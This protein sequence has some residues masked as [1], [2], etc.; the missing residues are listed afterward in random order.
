MIQIA[1]GI[2][3][4]GLVL[5][6]GYRSF[7]Q[8]AR[9]GST[10]WAGIRRDASV[11]ERI[12]AGLFV[13]ALLA[14]IAGLVLAASSVGPVA[15]PPKTVAVVGLAVEAA[16]LVVLIVAQDGMGDAW[17]IGVDPDEHTD[18]VTSGL[19]G[20][21]RNPIFTA[22]VAAQAG[23]VIVAPNV[24]GVAAL[25]ALV[26][27]VQLQVRIVE[28]PYLQ[29]T[30]PMYAAYASRVGRFVPGIGRLPSTQPTGR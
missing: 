20:L 1:L 27:A 7:A 15:E 14:G 9:T 2:Y 23:A 22:M 19:F 10:G 12:A 28:E 3:G 6:F 18:L 16:G 29:R 21:V 11:V 25:A 5:A 4:A 30:H 26:V 8:Y 17:R 13:V 24:V